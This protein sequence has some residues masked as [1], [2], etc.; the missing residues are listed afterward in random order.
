MLLATA[1][2]LVTPAH[3]QDGALPPAPIQNDEGGPVIIDG[4]MNY[5]NPE[6]FSTVAQPLIVLEDQAGFIDR[7]R[8]FVLPPESQALGVITGD[9]FSPPFTWT[10]SLPTVPQG[11]LRDVDQDGEEDKG[12]MTYAVAF[13]SNIFGDPYLERRD[14]SGGGWSTAYATTRVKTNP[15]GGGEVIGGQYVVWAPDDQQGF[16]SGFGE[17]GKLFTADDPIVRLP[18]GYTIVDMDTDPF[19]FDRTRLP[20]MDADRTG[21]CCAGRLLR[22]QLHRSLRR[23][24][25]HVP[26]GVC[27][28]RTQGHRLGRTRGRVPA[29]L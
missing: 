1:F 20:K 12:V 9:F 21:R 26:R 4:E 5:T 17:D 29:A 15:S 22:P 19:T 6:S 27:L 7:D 23:D 3:A 24:G 11:T 8:G 2:L 18:A 16:P 28:H 14:L 25:R 13:W 10:L